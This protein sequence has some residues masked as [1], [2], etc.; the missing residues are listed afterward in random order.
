MSGILEGGSWPTEKRKCYSFIIMKLTSEKLG[1]GLRFE[2]SRR[3]KL[4]KKLD[5][6]GP[7]G[8]SQVAML[9]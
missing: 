4:R 7:K 5:L 3:L 2:K 8:R 9:R 1:K 6:L